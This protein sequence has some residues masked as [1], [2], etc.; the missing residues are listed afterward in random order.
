[1]GVIV[2]RRKRR[3]AIGRDRQLANVGCGRRIG[4]RVEGGHV[5]SLRQSARASRRPVRSIQPA[6]Q[7]Q[8]IIAAV[9]FGLV[10]LP[11]LS[12]GNAL[13]KRRADRSSKGSSNLLGGAAAAIGRGRGGIDAKPPVEDRLERREDG[14]GI[15]RTIDDRGGAKPPQL[16]IADIDRGNAGGRRFHDAAGGVAD[17]GIRKPQRGPVALAAERGEQFRLFRTRGDEVRD[18][19]VDRAIAGIGVDAGE[20]EAAVA[21]VSQRAQQCRDIRRIRLRLCGGRMQGDQQEALGA[22]QA[23]VAQAARRGRSRALRSR[24]RDRARR[25]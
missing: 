14:G 25:H 21:D 7:M 1:M 4:E 16:A 23:R 19:V 6:T 11:Q 2:D 24:D 8:A 20:D 22:A 17:H 5:A 9:D 13:G 15:G 18:R 10:D 12:H 3:A